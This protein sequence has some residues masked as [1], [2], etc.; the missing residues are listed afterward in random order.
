MSLVIIVPAEDREAVR[1]ALEAAGYGPNNISVPMRGSVRVDDDELATHY[2]S[3]MWE[4]DD[5]FVEIVKEHS[6]EAVLLSN[7][8][9]EGIEKRDTTGFELFDGEAGDYFYVP[10]SQSQIE[11]L[12]LGLAKLVGRG[13]RYARVISSPR[14]GFHPL[15]ELRANDIVPISLEAD[16][17]P[18][19]SVLE[20]FVEDGALTQDEKDGIV[21]AVAAMA[22]QTVKVAAFIP[23]SWQPYVMTREQAKQARYFGSDDQ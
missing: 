7:E 1:S 15:L 11:G 22:G 21:Y 10:C 8:E 6:P 4:L 2:G 12:N 20:V 18:L 13:E 9:R 14:E 5:D 23:A 3:H 16:P 17:G 19:E